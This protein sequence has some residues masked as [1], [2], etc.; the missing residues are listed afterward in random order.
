MKTTTTEGV[1]KARLTPGQQWV[2]IKN[3]ILDERMQ[4]RHETDFKWMSELTAFR[5][6]GSEFPAVRVYQLPDGRLFAA[7]G[8]HRI[9]AMQH[10]NEEQVLCD[11]VDGT[12]EDA[13]VFAAGSNKGNGVK[14]MGPKD[15]TKAVEM[16]LAIDAW[17]EK[18]NPSIGRHVG[19][20]NGKVAKIRSRFAEHHS[21]ELP[22]VVERSNGVFQPYRTFMTTGKKK[23]TKRRYLNGKVSG[24]QTKHRGR[25]IY[26]P[27]DEVLQAKIDAIMEA[28]SRRLTAKGLDQVLLR[29]GFVKLLPMSGY[30]GIGGVKSRGSVMC[31]PCDCKVVESIPQ[32]IGKLIAVRRY[33]GDLTARMVVLCY[34]EDGPAKVLDLYRAEGFEFLTPEELIES[35]KEGEA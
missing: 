22:E 33:K 26:A 14:P 3:I 23:I 10:A 29:N 11:V 25:T 19:C 32:A 35:L 18:G 13:I 7:S 20:S 17:W 31:T 5:K 4:P 2:G 21:K 28:E 30:G 9:P 34:P 6:D 15:I 27:T 8:H 24:V 16:L 12:E 1:N